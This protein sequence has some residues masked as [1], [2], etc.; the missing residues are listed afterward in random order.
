MGDCK[1]RLTKGLYY[2][3]QG[4]KERLKNEKLS[5]LAT[6]LQKVRKMDVLES[7]IKF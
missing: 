6:L 4:I 5:Q 3:I 1:S 7:K 2:I